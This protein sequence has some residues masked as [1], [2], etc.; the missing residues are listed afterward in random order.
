MEN[1]SR[2]QIV[3]LTLIVLFGLIIYFVLQMPQE[4]EEEKKETS[5]KAEVK[6]ISETQ[7]WVGGNIVEEGFNISYESGKE[8]LIITITD[9]PFITSVNKA[10]NYLT[11]RGYDF[12]TENYLVLTGT[13]I[14]KDA[15]WDKGMLC[16]K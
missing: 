8:R 7:D 3:V 14:A 15:N 12:C 11:T 4:K 9:T 5:D 16:E 13:G 6:I 10:K 1:L 2:K